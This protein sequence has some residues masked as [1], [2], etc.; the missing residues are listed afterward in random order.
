[1]L[2]QGGHM[3][4]KSGKCQEKKYVHKHIHIYVIRI[5]VSCKKYTYHI[6]AASIL[7]FIK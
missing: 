7:S 1:M 4:G 5:Y 2:N 6:S 3:F